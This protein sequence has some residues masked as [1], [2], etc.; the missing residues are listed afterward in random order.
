M[1][2]SDDPYSVLVMRVSTRFAMRVSSG[3]RDDP[4]RKREPYTTSAS[5]PKHGEHQIGELCRV[6]LQVGVLHGGDG[7][8]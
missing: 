8:S 6:E 2:V 4:D 3:A 1:S 7:S 5:P